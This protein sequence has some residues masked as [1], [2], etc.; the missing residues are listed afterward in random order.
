MIGSTIFRLLSKHQR[1]ESFMG[2][3]MVVSFL[4]LATPIIW[5]NHVMIIFMAF[6][7]FEICVGIFWP[8][9]GF[10]RGIYIP[11]ATRATI[12][13]FCRVPLNAVVITILLQN[14]SHQTILQCC[15][16][17]LMLA[18]VVQQYLCRIKIDD[19]IVKPERSA[20]N[21]ITQE[22]TSIPESANL[23]HECP[24]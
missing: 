5:P 15:V 22:K 3:V 24:D 19:R 18:T 16:I 13:N 7:F 11:E 23:P 17:F 8:S 10:M 14:L 1:P 9:I 4:C 20:T 21:A 2:F 12:M 6:V